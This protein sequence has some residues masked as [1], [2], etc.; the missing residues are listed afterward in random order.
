LIES[1][2]TVPLLI[3]LLSYAIRRRDSP[4]HC[5]STGARRFQWDAHFSLDREAAAKQVQALTLCFAWERVTIIVDNLGLT[6]AQR[7]SVNRH[8]PLH[9]VLHGREKIH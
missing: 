2:Q 5:R 4:K 1:S 3:V 7:D 9:C 8:R 6:R